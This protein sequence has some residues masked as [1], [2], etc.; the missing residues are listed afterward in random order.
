VA[1]LALLALSPGP[2]PAQASQRRNAFAVEALGGM[3]G[4]LTGIAIV[5]LSTRCGVED[6]ACIITKVGAGGALGAVGA[7]A[8]TI[9]AARAMRSPSSIGGALL[10][11]VVGTGVGLGVHWLFNRSSDRNLGDAIVVPIFVV[12]QGAF[13]ALGSRALAR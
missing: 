6:L 13:A 4:S 8:G 10:G 7:T 9:I 5:G 2:M 12:A 1:L 3:A 11:S